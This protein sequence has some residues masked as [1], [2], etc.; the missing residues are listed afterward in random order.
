MLI[1]PLWWKNLPGDIYLLDSPLY[2]LKDHHFEKILPYS[3][4][5]FRKNL[6]LVG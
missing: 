2:K 5:P 6:R 3:I 1:D 4:K